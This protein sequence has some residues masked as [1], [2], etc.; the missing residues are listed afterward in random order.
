MDTSLV[1]VDVQTNYVKV[2]MK[3]KV[4][5]QKLKCEK[6]RI[7]KI[8]KQTTFNHSINIYL[9]SGFQWQ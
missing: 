6:R 9:L 5:K 2:I 8:A 1:D 7:D 4:G 3:G